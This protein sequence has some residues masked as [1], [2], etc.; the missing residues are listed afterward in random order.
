VKQKQDEAGH[1]VP[2]RRRLLLVD[3]SEANLEILGLIFK[4]P[5]YET[6]NACD[7]VDGMEKLEREARFDAILLDLMM[8]RMDGLQML[9]A[10]KAD[11]RYR[12]I[13]VIVQTAIGHP[14][15]VRQVMQAGAYYCLVKPY[16]DRA[17]RSVVE[18]ALGM[19]NDEKAE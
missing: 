4:E 6:V 7:G 16:D 12:D 3:D 10:L 13:P 18:R 19:K 8:P 1:G 9:K 11:P 2:P 15:Q 5:E 14:D 17:A